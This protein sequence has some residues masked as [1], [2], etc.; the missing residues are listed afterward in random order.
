VEGIE[1]DDADDDVRPILV[2]LGVSED[3]GVVGC[4]E[5]HVVVGLQGRR[6]AADLVD[7]GDD[8]DDVARRLPVANLDLVFLRVEVLL[9]ARNGLVLAQLVAAVDA[10][11]T[12]QRSRQNGAHDERRPAAELQDRRQDVRGVGEEVAGE[13]LLHLASRSAR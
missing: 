6:L 9:L 13:V 1:V 12:G 2:H 7:P 8:I 5:E 3:V 10:I 11:D 4:Q